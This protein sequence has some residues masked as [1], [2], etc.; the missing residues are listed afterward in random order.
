MCYLFVNSTLHHCRAIVVFDITFPTSL[1]HKSI[2]IDLILL[3]ALLAEIVN[4][5]IV[6][7]R[8]EVVNVLWYS[9]VLKFVH[10]ACAISFDL[11][12]SRDSQEDNFCKFLLWK[13]SKNTTSQNDRLLT[14]Y[15]LHYDHCLMHSVHHKAYDVGPWHT[16]QLLSDDVLEIN[17]MAHRLNR[18]KVFNSSKHLL[19]VSNNFEFDDAFRLF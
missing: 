15:L 14:S 11:L 1:D 6:S 17:Q 5:I 18:S 12:A 16:R 4:S 10:Q 19:I 2:I 7:I 3:K 8:K 9:V 13:R